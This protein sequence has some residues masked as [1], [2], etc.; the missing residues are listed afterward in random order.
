MKFLTDQEIIDLYF[1]TSGRFGPA[2]EVVEFAR[3][4]EEKVSKEVLANA[5]DSLK[6]M[7]GKEKN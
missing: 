5:K 1:G 4:I 2:G 7:N 6:W 3:Q